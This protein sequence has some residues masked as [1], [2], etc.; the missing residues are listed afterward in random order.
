MDQPTE[1]SS[2]VNFRE[3]G[4]VEWFTLIYLHSSP[5]DQSKIQKIRRLINFV[6][7]FDDTDD[8]VAYINSISNQKAILIVSAHF[9]DSLFPRIEN[10]PQ[11][12]TIYILSANPNDNLWVSS[13]RIRGVYRSIDDIYQMIS[14]DVDPIKLDLLAVQTVYKSATEVDKKNSAFSINCRN[15]Y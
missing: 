6:K 4:N 14:D 8:C 7:S 5:P 13:D 2:N 15:S 3:K 10:A 12:S 11:I 9:C 1:T